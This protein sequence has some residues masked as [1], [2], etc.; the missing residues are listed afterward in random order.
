MRTERRSGW[1]TFMTPKD[2]LWRSCRRRSSERASRERALFRIVR[3]GGVLGRCILAGHARFL[4]RGPRGAVLHRCGWLFEQ[5]LERPKEGRGL[6][7]GDLGL[8]T[9]PARIALP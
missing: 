1:R 2:D 7:I 9:P 6:V 4:W 5:G 3:R 8:P